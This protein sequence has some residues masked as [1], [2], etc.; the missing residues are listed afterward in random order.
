MGTVSI[1]ERPA[2]RVWNIGQ[3]GTETSVTATY[4]VR[5][6]PAS[7]TDAYPGDTVILT[8]GSLPKP[9]TR[10]PSTLHGS[11]PYI[12]QMICRSV[13]MTP[14]TAT[15]YAW[16]VNATYTGT[17]N[18]YDTGRYCRMT[19][20]ASERM[21]GQ[22]RTYTSIP[23]NGA[24]TWP[25]TDMGGTK[26]DLHGTPRPLSVATESITL[27]YVHDRSGATV[28][29]PTE[30]DWY[31]F[32]QAQGTRNSSVM[33]NGVYAIGTLLYRGCQATLEQECWRLVHLWQFDNL[34]H[35]DQV[36]CPNPTGQ[37]VL[38]ASGT[39]NGTTGFM[40][41]SQVGWYQRYPTLSNH[42]TMLP[43]TIQGALTSSY[44]A[45]A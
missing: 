14:E 4:L 6:I 13:S 37:P 19:K 44:P 9:T 28:G 43:S 42:L 33:F 15:P 35:L 2:S 27:E 3:K 24:A 25:P 11:D 8:S 34:W 26:L 36:P 23:T 1:I 39:F 41:T 16:Q 12:K 20:S 29:T 31:A 38:V 7:D 21:M 18:P 40:Q 30:P 45:L 32:G 17:A 22:Y 5:W 10:A